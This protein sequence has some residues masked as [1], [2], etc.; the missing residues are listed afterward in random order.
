MTIAPKQCGRQFRISTSEGVYHFS[1]PYSLPR[2]ETMIRSTRSTCSLEEGVAL[3]FREFA[4]F[5]KKGGLGY[6]SRPFQADFK[7]KLPFSKFFDADRS[8]ATQVIDVSNHGFDGVL[9]TL[10]GRR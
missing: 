6:L 4:K 7:T 1:P 3:R 9:Q 10:V 8:Q 5:F 2:Q